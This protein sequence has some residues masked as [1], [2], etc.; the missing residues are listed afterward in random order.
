MVFYYTSTGNSLYIARQFSD[1]PVSIPQEMK[2]DTLHYKDEVIGI[3]C[4]DYTGELPQIVRRF[5]EKASFEAKYVFLL[6]TYGHRATVSAEWGTAFCARHGLKIDYAENVLMVDNFL[7]AFDMKAE[8]AID[9]QIPAQLARLRADIN[10]RVTGI[11]QCSDEERAFYQS[12]VERNRNMPQILPSMMLE[13]KSEVCNGCGI[14]TRVCPVGSLAVANG[15]AVRTSD[16]CE[17]CLGC[18]QHC[19]Q[20][21]VG[22]RFPE[23]NPDARYRHPEITLNDIIQA[24]CQI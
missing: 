4:P 5:I 8:M 13:I 23:R 7:P 14:C 21:A 16:T 2:K 3:V 6:V 9:K 20:K 22:L 19:P 24:N 12:V 11:A 15:K 18:V 17:M 10:A 1:A